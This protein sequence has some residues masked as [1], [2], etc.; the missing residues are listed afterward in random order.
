MQIN[1]Q[2]AAYA[3][4]LRP[5]ASTKRR[6]VLRAGLALLGLG[7]GAPLARAAEP[8]AAM[9]AMGRSASASGAKKAFVA[10]MMQAMD[11]MDHAMAA[12]PMNGDPDH[13]FLSMMIPHHQGA[14]EMAKLILLYGK[15][16]HI[17][18]LAEGII[19]EQ[20]NEIQIMRHWLAMMPPV[21]H[22]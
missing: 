21:T 13:D 20:E 3:G 2:V 19:A 8:K 17:R 7:A 15:N 22:P 5:D 4:P 1:L 11:H 9:S 14:I 12:A 10:K 6:S 18:N 16:V